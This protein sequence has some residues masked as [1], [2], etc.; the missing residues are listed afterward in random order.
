[1][2]ITHS[3]KASGTFSPEVFGLVCLCFMLGTSVVEGQTGSIQPTTQQKIPPLYVALMKDQCRIRPLNPQAGKQML[4][5]DNTTESSL[6][7]KMASTK[8]EAAVV[9]RDSIPSRQQWFSV[10]DLQSGSYIIS[11]PVIRGVT[12]TI[13][14]R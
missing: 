13:T 10:V 12:C 1:M 9:T 6:S 3:T 14:V 8:T 7:V 4:I 5:L 2:E 11:S